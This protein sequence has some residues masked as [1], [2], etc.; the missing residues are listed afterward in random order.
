METKD[1]IDNARFYIPADLYDAINGS[2]GIKK[3]NED[4]TNRI[5]KARAEQD[6]YEKE[7]KKELQGQVIKKL[8]FDDSSVII[9]TQN[10]RYEFINN[11]ED[12]II[13]KQKEQK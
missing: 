4:I 8:I 5:E 12:V 13:E 10:G 11:Y 9:E 6:N 1:E 3:Y 7:M 2:E